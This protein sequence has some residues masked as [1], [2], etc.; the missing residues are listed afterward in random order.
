ML[1]S[2]IIGLP[3]T[4]VGGDV[5]A[6]S[7]IEEFD[8]RV[9][10]IRYHREEDSR[11]VFEAEVLEWRPRKKEWVPIRQR[12][13]CSGYFYNLVEN[14]HLHV[15]AEEVEDE[16]YGPQWQIYVSERV[17]PGTTTEML[18]FLTSIKGVGPSIGRR[19]L[20]AFGLDVIST[21]LSDAT[22]LN[23]LGLP[24]PA[25]DNLYQAIVENQ[26]FESLLVFL[27]GHSLSPKY[28]TQIYK[29]YGSHAVEKIR[30]NPYSLYLDRVIDFP[31]AARLDANMGSRCPEN[32]RVQAT[33]LACL[34]DNAN[35][36]G[37]LYI[38]E[39]DLMEKIAA[40][41]QHT[42]YDTGIPLPTKDALDNALQE[43]AGSGS[44]IVDSLLGEG[45]PIYLYP[46]F[47]AEK[48]IA[49]RLTE[50]VEEPK[51]LWASRADIDDAIT[52]AQGKLTLS[53]EQQSA[54]RTAFLSPVSVLTGGP[55]TGKTQ[56]LEILVTAAKQLWPGVNIR[57]CAPT[58]KAAMRAQEVIGVEASTIHRALG[59]P[60][61][62][63]KKDELV[64]DMLIADEYSMCDATLCSWM[65]EALNSSAKLLIVGD[66]E[67]L[68]SVG[69]GL[70]LRD[71]IDSEMIPVSRLTQVFR[72]S[73][74]S[75]ITDNAHTI[76]RTPTG[77]IPTGL[78]WSDAKG[79]SFYLV[80]AKSHR[81]IQ[82]MVIR[83]V[84][85]MLDEGFPLDQIVVLSPIH[86]GPVGT[87]ALNCLLQRELNPIAASFGCA[88]YPLSNGGELR[89]GDKV[90]QMRNDYDLSV[91]NGE[92]GVVKQVDFSPSRAVC[93]G[94]PGRDIWYDAKQ[95]EDLDLAYSITAHRSQGSEFQAVVIPICVSLLY[96]VDKNV[97]YT[98]I[99]RAKKRVVFVGSET[100]LDSALSKGG[101]M[102]RN[103]HL[104]LRIQE[105]FLAV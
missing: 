29:M 54:I 28:A 50:L 24:Q 87:D 44:I 99:T 95:A 30:D 7:K 103:S 78:M 49:Q 27:Q 26:S 16:I 8:I 53:Y 1:A 58:G 2:H 101:A 15:S 46:H 10:K 92:T 5:V 32:Y 97:I 104:A 67:Q 19:L 90:I 45:R 39:Q 100:A 93:V 56:T 20:D 80:K 76:I 86:G 102:D 9:R 47:K 6:V 69:P 51:R 83:S 61:Q 98:A 37:D 88:S 65:L 81:K 38:E 79:G 17:I 63:L 52:R 91:F 55:G 22:C 94:Y 75:Y 89:P 96:H 60:H 59:Y 84:K 57:V 43:L 77:D 73:S 18:K 14:D 41:F 62:M 31:A 40:Y 42:L 71:L 12:I 11:T 33:V 34:W 74:G 64:C 105:S 21:I 23:S 70:V 36:Q 82:H 48:A 72:Q 66:H 25:K 13:N 3:H 85:R 35:G 4:S 68:P